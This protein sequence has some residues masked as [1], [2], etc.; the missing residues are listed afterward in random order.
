M[1]MAAYGAYRTFS[2]GLPGRFA[3]AYAGMATVGLGSESM[4]FLIRPTPGR[5]HLAL[6]GHWERRRPVTMARELIGTG[7]VAKGATKLTASL[8][9]RSPARLLVPRHTQVGGSGEF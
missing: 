2:E 8:T 3:A 7:G 4:G 6:G 5:V 1:G 9:F